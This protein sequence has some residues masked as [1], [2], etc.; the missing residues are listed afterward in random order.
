VHAVALGAGAK[1]LRLKDVLEIHRH[2]TLA[3]TTPQI[4]GELRERQNWIGGNAYNP[5]T[6]SRPTTRRCRRRWADPGADQG[7]G[8]AGTRVLLASLRS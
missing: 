7:A 4:A 8:N 1:P 5:G 2:L 6:S 3:T